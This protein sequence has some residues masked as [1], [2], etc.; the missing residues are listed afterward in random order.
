MRPKATPTSL[1][2]VHPAAKRG[3]R[4]AADLVAMVATEPVAKC[5]PQC[6][7]SVV[8]NAKYHLSLEKADQSIAA[9]ATARSD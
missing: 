2:A 6:V 8:K 9:I 4:S 3:K 5:S 1:S 7:L